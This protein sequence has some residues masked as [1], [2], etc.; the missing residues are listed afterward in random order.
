[1]QVSC[2]AGKHEGCASFHLPPNS[3]ELFT[4]FSLPFLH[5]YNFSGT[6]VEWVGRR[7]PV[8]PGPHQAVCLPRSAVGTRLLF[9]LLQ[10]LPGLGASQVSPPTSGLPQRQ[11]EDESRLPPGTGSQ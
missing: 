6:Q 7:S 1:M 10:L 3:L 9:P 11:R 8:L 2:Q 5:F 4:L